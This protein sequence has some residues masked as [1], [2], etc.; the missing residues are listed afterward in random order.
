[1][2]EPRDDGLEQLVGSALRHRAAGAPDR[3]DLA[4]VKTR[5]AR[6]Q[7]VRRRAGAGSSALA[8]AVV[9]AVVA[10]TVGRTPAGNS[11]AA[12]SQ[13]GVVLLPSQLLRGGPMTGRLV[14]PLTGALDAGSLQLSSQ[15]LSGGLGVGAAAQ[16]PATT[17]S[18][19]RPASNG[20]SH[21]GT[22][23][24]A[25]QTVDVPP[26]SAQ[27]LDRL[28]TH[29][30][31]DG[32]IASTF[33][34]P[35]PPASTLPCCTF[36]GPRPSGSSQAGSAPPTSTTRPQSPRAPSPANSCSPT[37]EVT[38]EISDT[39][40]VATFTEPFYG[41]FSTP[42]VDVEIGEI[43]VTEGT[44]ATWVEAEVGA[45]AVEVVMHFADG[46]TDSV[47][48]GG[49][50]AVLAHLGDAATVLGNGSQASLQVLGSGGVVLATYEI[51]VGA[52]APAPAPA[53]SKNPSPTHSG[54]PSTTTG[55]HT[56][57]PPTGAHQPEHPKAA[58]AAVGQALAT[59]LSC[60]E[61]PVAQSQAVELGGSFEEVGGAGS[62]GLFLGDRIFVDQVVFTSG[63]RAVVSFHVA[64]AGILDPETLYASA[65]LVGRSWL[66]SLQSV[67]PGLQVAPANQDG[68]VTVAPGGPLYVRTG[69]G[70]VTIAVYRAEPASAC[71]GAGCAPAP[72]SSQCLP[73]GGVVEEVTTPGA[74]GIVASPLFANYTTPFI[75]V[76]LSIVGEA[77][78]SPATVVATEVGP[79]VEAVRVATGSGTQSVAPV[80]GAADTVL[81]GAPA[82]AIGASGGSLDALGTSGATLATIPLQ[83]DATAPAPASTLPRALPQ[84]GTGP[85]DPAAA[86]AA[87]DQVFTTVFS[88]ASSPLVRA[89]NIQDNGLFS[90]PLEQLYVGPFTSLVES[91][92]AT[93]GAVV[94]RSPTLADVA[95][96]IGFKSDPTLTFSMIGTAILLDGTWRVSY[97][98][99]C[100]AV[101]LGGVTCST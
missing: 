19:S 52:P 51:G 39:R 43:G 58:R 61:P 4:A 76:G 8:L 27:T 6:R 78:G 88:C 82:S 5:A 36:Q 67:A 80:D 57:L 73:T 23:A 96:T 37:G 48:P 87:I 86:T 2:T 79:G 7:R 55:P 20:S 53:P 65:T 44:P 74:V 97:A 101:A 1:M 35:N 85:A 22:P 56:S 93:V 11:T 24:P 18:S 47:S 28:A 9:V 100:A 3:P 31:P 63:T 33:Y 49:K 30:S 66:V 17:F 26:G 94:F 16:G 21:G 75:A 99:L 14:L 45:S 70:G 60:S 29:V 68:G 77:E 84:P 90:N 42:L 83:V 25:S 54:L 91:V 38:I 59:A 10:S 34:T 12:S 92:Y 40:A 64:G 15:S 13:G 81:A 89:E 71:S 46:S 98:T 50:V 72:P 95:Y 62:S 69:A 41:G 32:V